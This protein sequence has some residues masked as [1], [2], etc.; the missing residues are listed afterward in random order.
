M[1]WD[2]EGDYPGMVEFATK[3]KEALMRAHNSIIEAWVK[4]TDCYKQHVCWTLF[5]FV[6]HRLYPFMAAYLTGR[7]H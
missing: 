4:Q 7:L 5:S 3:I 1:V 2:N 6:M